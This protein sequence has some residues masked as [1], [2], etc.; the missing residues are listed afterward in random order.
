MFKQTRILGI[1]Y[2][3]KRIGLAISDT[4]AQFGQ[5]YSV[6]KNSRKNLPE[7]ISEISDILKKEEVCEIVLGESKDF[8]GKDNA[9]MPE[10]T[11]FKEKLEKTLFDLS[12]QI[13]V[14]FEPEF[15]T[16]HQAAYFQGKHDLLDASSAALI[17]QSYLDR[18]NNILKNKK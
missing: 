18:K 3:T 17:L 7:V 9:V 5:P 2:G 13:P 16:S 8:K 4:D 14:I 6:I 1:D 15:L 10:I 12:M 11:E